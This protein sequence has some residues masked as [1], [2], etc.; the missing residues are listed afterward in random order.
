MSVDVARAVLTAVTILFFSL[1]VFALIVNYTA[2]GRRKFHI[3]TEDEKRERRLKHFRVQ[4]DWPK[5]YWIHT[6]NGYGE[7]SHR[8]VE[9][10]PIVILA[11][12]SLNTL[13]LHSYDGDDQEWRV[14]EST[15]GRYILGVRSRWAEYLLLDDLAELIEDKGI[16]YLRS[17]VQEGIREYGPLTLEVEKGVT[18]DAHNL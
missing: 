18:N 3:L 9:G 11:D 12:R 6:R 15:T 2:W 5:W 4:R 16:E 14:S 8:K 7:E 1:V 13:F 17:K 10:Y